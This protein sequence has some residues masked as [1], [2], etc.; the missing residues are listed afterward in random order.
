[1]TI[2]LFLLVEKKQT[3]PMYILIV[4]SDR[5]VMSTVKKTNPMKFLSS[6]DI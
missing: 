4:K 1:M 6:S 3:K 5:N 2:Q